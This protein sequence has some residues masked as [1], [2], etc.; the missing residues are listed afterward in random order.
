MSHLALVKPIV[1]NQTLMSMLDRAR[2]WAGADGRYNSSVVQ[3]TTLGVYRACMDLWKNKVPN[4]HSEESL[5]TQADE[6]L[7]RLENDYGP[8]FWLCWDRQLGLPHV[9]EIKLNPPSLPPAEKLEAVAALWETSV[10]H[11]H[12]DNK[13]VYTSPRRAGCLVVLSLP[14]FARQGSLLRSK[15]EEYGKSYAS[16]LTAAPLIVFSFPEAVIGIADD[17]LYI[18]EDTVFGEPGETPS[19]EEMAADFF[20]VNLDQL[21]TDDEPTFFVEGVQNIRITIVTKEDWENDDGASIL[22]GEELEVTTEYKE[23]VVIKHV[24]GSFDNGDMSAHFNPNEDDTDTE[25]TNE[26]EL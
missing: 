5:R 3:G 6:A 23:Y 8:S 1:L 7:T 11:I 25:N 12:T 20:G 2:I 17:E 19:Q 10:T 22:E 26:E 13:L 4:L 16:T 9:Q 15:Y 21:N 14:E 18:S 24:S